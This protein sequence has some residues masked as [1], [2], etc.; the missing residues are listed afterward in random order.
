MR[1]GRKK[2]KKRETEAVRGM[3]LNSSQHPFILPSPLLYLHN[4]SCTERRKKKNSCS[5]FGIRNPGCTWKNAL[6]IISPL[7]FLFFPPSPPPFFFRLPGAW[8]WPTPAI[9]S[10]R[11]TIPWRALVNSRDFSRPP[12]WLAVGRFRIF[13]CTVNHCDSTCLARDNGEFTTE[14]R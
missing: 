12:I 9:L 3:H 5:F 7:L 1:G 2:G 6:P 13:R 14:L 8:P 4:A 10:T 11:S